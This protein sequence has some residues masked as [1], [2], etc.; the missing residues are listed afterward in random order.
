MSASPLPSPAPEPVGKSASV[1]I[2]NKCFACDSSVEHERAWIPKDGPKERTLI[3]CF[4]GTKDS[5]DQDVSQ[6][7]NPSYLIPKTE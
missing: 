6:L 7:S 5:F 4:D 1:H 2:L 3:L